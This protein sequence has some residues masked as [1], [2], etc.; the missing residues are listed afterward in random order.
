[1]LS[2]FRYRNFFRRKPEAQD[3]LFVDLGV[4][5]HFGD[6]TREL[7][8]QNLL[9][10]KMD[11]DFLQFHIFEEKHETGPENKVLSD[12]AD[13]RQTVEGLRLEAQSHD[14]GLY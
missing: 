5:A 3:L 9:F 2:V 13:L 11:R 1:M 10:Q 8:D 12:G 6:F 14:H 7:G 4:L